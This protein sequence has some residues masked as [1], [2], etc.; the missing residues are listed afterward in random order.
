MNMLYNTIPQ[1]ICFLFLFTSCLLFSCQTEEKEVADLILINGQVTTLDKA[2]PS[3]EAI[4][5]KGDRL[6]KIGSN[7]EI[8]TLVGDNTKTI[9]LK[10]NFVIPGIIEGHGHFSSLGN[11]LMNLNF[12][13]SKSWQ[14]MVAEVEAAAK[15][16][17]PGEWITGR[18][19][20]QEKWTSPIGKQV[21]GYPYHDELSAVSPNNPV[22]LGHASGHSVFANKKAMDLAGVSAETPNP[23]GGEIVRDARGA[24]IGVFE[25]TAMG[26]ISNSYDEYV[27]TLSEEEKL[28]KWYKSIEL[29]EEECLKKGIT[30]FQDAGSTFKE[31]E[32]Y[33]KLAEEGKLDLRLWAMIGSKEKNLEENLPNFP[34]INAGNQFFTCRAI[35][36]YMD[37]ALGSF[38]AWLLADYE[39]KPDFFGQN[40]TPIAD[41]QK[42]GELAAK[43]NLQ[44]CVHAIGDRG[45]REVLNIY[46]DIFKKHPQSSDFRWRIE[47]AQHIDLADIPRFKELGVIA[48]MQAIH[49]TSDS[50]FVM[51]RLGEKRAK[52]SAYPWRTLL[53][54][55]VVVSNGTDAPVEDVDPIENFY[56]TVTRK[57]VDN[58]TPFYPEQSM[59]RMEALISY[60]LT[61]A[62]AAFEEKEKGS[63][64]IGKLADITV[65]S[66]NLLTCKEGEIMNTEVLYTIVGG[67]VKHSKTD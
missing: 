2:N 65:L 17:K 32:R 8:Q 37:G 22:I 31:I 44:Y 16:A 60:T 3:A 20:H 38:G 7:Q 53:D 66:N 24:P 33:K 30:S 54:A 57:R 52:E 67:V 1:R 50:P 9:D 11:S 56:A 40:V 45:N 59:T 18:G 51:K 64:E 63:L 4:A 36:G 26:I 28:E 58:P 13:R 10:G 25:E 61:N 35:K 46:E 12:L 42:I 55:G 41:L 34:I 49:C 39:E 48:S 19:W 14:S 29:V 15:T 47:H 23:S 6:F 27:A 21:L 62:Y 43:H 5:V